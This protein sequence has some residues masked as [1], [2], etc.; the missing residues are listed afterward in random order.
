MTRAE[1]PVRIEALA[2]AKINLTLHVLERRADGYHALE[3]LVA[4]A[5]AGDTLALTP[6]AGLSLVVE[7]PTAEQ[8]GEERPERAPVGESF[9][10]P[11]DV[12]DVPSF[13]RDE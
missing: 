1:T 12:L 3:S 9:D 4:F 6:E 13:L 7:G 10:V 11:R 8:A 5:G 2:P